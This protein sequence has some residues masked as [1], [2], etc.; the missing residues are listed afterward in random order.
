MKEIGETVI[1]DRRRERDEGEQRNVS[2]NRLN[3]CLLVKREPGLR[4]IKSVDKA[5]QV[6]TKEIRQNEKKKWRNENDSEIKRDW[7]REQGRMMKCKNMGK[8][9]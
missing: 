2:K 5:R 9:R 4:T 3:H 1:N 8:G 6:E 7:N